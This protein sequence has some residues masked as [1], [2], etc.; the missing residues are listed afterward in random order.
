MLIDTSFDF[1]IDTPPGKGKDPDKDSPTLRRYHKLLW[2]KALPDGALFDLNDAKRG[3]YLHHRSEL[4][5][6]FLS[7][8]SAIS[9]FT[10]WGFAK[11]HPEL[12]TDEDNEA[13][14][15]IAYT[16]GG[17]MV[18]PGI[19]DAIRVM[20]QLKFL[21]IRVI[22][23]SQGID[24][25]S[26]QADALVA[27]HGLIDS[28]YLKE[29]AK[30]VKRG[31]AGQMD[32]GFSTGARQY[33]FRKILVS[34]PSGKKDAHGQLVA[35]GTRIEVNPDEA[36]VIQ[37][38]FEWAA[39]GVGLTTIVERLN[40]K[41]IPGTAGKRW[42]KTPVRRILK[43]ERYLGRQIWGQQSVEHE[44]GTGRKIMRDNPR[45]EWRMEDRPE[46]RIVSDELWHRAQQTRSEVRKSVAPKQN[47]ARGKDARF[48]SKHLFTGFAKC[49][50]CGGAM[51]TVSGGS[52][53]PRLGCNRSWNQGR[54]ACPN[55]LTIRIKVAEPQILAKLQTEL[56][57]PT[58]L[59]HITKL[60]EKEIQRALAAPKAVANDHQRQLEQERKK[61]Q[62]L[63]AAIEGGASVPSTLLKA[64]ADREATIKR[65]E[66]EQR[67]REEKPSGK[68]L[69]DLPSWVGEQLKDLAGLLKSDP[70]KVKSEFRR[71]N[72][73]L[74]F[75]PTEAE[76][77]PHY[78]VKGQCDLG[79]LV[80]FYLRSRRQSAVLGSLR[81]LSRLSAAGWI[82]GLRVI[83]PHIGVECRATSASGHHERR[84]FHH[85][86][87]RGDRS[88]LA[89]LFRSSGCPI[90]GSFDD[91]VA[92]DD[93]E[94]AKRGH[95]IAAIAVAN[96]LAR[97]VRRVALGDLTSIR[98]RRNRRL[99]GDAS[100]RF[101]GLTLKSSLRPA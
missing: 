24:S 28:L 4:G 1:R 15:A 90:R 81:G 2:S 55:R 78:I 56:Q 93:Q 58:V 48:H 70:A 22:Y 64:I 67:K 17:M 8:D 96:T 37:T 79:A 26:E 53:S 63:I 25:A 52:G 89:I 14:M 77:R 42:S 73:Q 12:Y 95:N 32:R 23:I 43:N 61:L 9:T 10:R 87:D 27:V 41:G 46:L 30:K 71:L 50:L 94:L 21:G 97:T 91:R 20:Q 7:S 65:L 85:H 62:N 3:V 74:T 54:D 59:A 60:L 11:V 101:T 13:F 66:M 40:A 33:G 49:H 16:I 45:S 82:R 34:D 18:F 47:L 98:C 31:L 39:E 19:P 99:Q 83:G 86:P 92:H 36:K 44:P 88:Y 100:H 76:P 72:L 29:L 6:F 69:P 35:L 75:H 80:F 57:Q 84:P 51:T 5:E 68:K 38:I